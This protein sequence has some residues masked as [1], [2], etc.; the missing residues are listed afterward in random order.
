MA[1]VA[2][3]RPWAWGRQGETD[4]ATEPVF[5]QVQ[6]HVADEPWALVV[7]DAQL[8]PLA[9]LPKRGQGHLLKELLGLRRRSRG[10]AWKR[11]SSG[12]LQCRPGSRASL[13]V[14]GADTDAVRQLR[15]QRQ[16]KG[17]AGRHVR[18]HEGQAAGISRNR[19]QATGPQASASSKKASITAAEPR[20]LARLANSWRLG[21]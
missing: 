6:A 1:A 19:A 10:P 18:G 9:R 20:S 17:Q 4:F 5:T 8:D 21:A 13:E 15:G 11:A 7:S 14:S 3:P 12:R 16:G 2:H